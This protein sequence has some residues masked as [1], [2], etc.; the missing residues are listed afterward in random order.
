MVGYE[1][2]WWAGR[3]C[4]RQHCCSNA[5]FTHILRGTSGSLYASLL[6]TRAARSGSGGLPGPWPGP[7]GGPAAAMPL[8]ADD[9]GAAG[10]CRAAREDN[11][12][13]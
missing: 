9:W 1:V 10:S 11:V 3:D 13:G 7:F 2:E 4:P 6:L 5:R 12:H 8:V